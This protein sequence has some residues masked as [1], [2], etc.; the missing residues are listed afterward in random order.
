MGNGIRKLLG[1]GLFKKYMFIETESTSVVLVFFA[2]LVLLIE[3]LRVAYF[4][5]LPYNY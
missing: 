1:A 4:D 5:V 2:D 3:T